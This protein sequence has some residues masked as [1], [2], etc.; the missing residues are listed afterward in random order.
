MADYKLIIPFILK[1]EGGLS[2]AA[3]DTASRNPSPCII[4]GVTGWH[5]NKGITWST[6]SGLAGKLG[7]AATCEN[8]KTMPQSIWD[9]I[10]KNGY[11]DELNLDLVQNQAIANLA[12]DFAW[13]AG[14]V[15]AA[16]R[17]QMAVNTVTGKKL[18]VDGNIGPVTIAAINS[19]PI[20][21]LFT[22]FA[23][24]K[25]SFYKNLPGQAANQK[26]WD[27]RHQ[28]LV[29]FSQKYLTVLTL[30]TIGLLTGSF[31]FS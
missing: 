8:F 18:V 22:V 25:D 16:R 19:A 2:R 20:K 12:A 29:A 17:L 21:K 3:S 15:T 6:F 7:Y 9:K 26:G 23:E 24:L 11:W 28:Q 31:F 5:T 13:G 10:F 27:A 4:N 30:G 1:A 14:P